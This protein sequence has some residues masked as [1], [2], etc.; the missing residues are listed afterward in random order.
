[1]NL[2]SLCYVSVKPLFPLKNKPFLICLQSCVSCSLIEIR[3]A[4]SNRNSHTKTLQV[5]PPTVLAPPITA[6]TVTKCKT[7]SPSL[8]PNAWTQQRLRRPAC[9]S[10][11]SKSSASKA[12]RTWDSSCSALC[13]ATIADN[14]LRF[15]VPYGP[16]LCVSDSVW[17]NTLR[18]GMRAMEL[19][20]QL[21]HER[22]KFNC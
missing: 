22:R 21:G 8:H 2:I 11:A 5:C 3:S 18:I 6:G 14:D 20:R 15:R 10:S 16:L 17:T 7:P 13:P 9:K 1:M 19:L 4:C 12:C